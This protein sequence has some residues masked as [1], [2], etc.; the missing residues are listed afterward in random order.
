M[1][2]SITQHAL[3]PIDQIPLG[4]ARVFRAAGREIAVFR[5]RSGELLATGATCPHRGGPLADGLV[6]GHS[7]ICPLHGF[8]F[9]LRSGEP[10]GR[11]CN[12]LQ[13]YRVTSSASGEL[14]LELT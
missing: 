13:T 2:L 12:R 9:D 11:D 7:V 10:I 8:L 6:G 3:G 14:T 4:E 5:L 1:T